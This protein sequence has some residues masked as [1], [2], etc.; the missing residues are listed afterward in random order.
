MERRKYLLDEKE[1]FQVNSMIRN[2]YD[3]Q[4]FFVVNILPI[5]V[6]KIPFLFFRPK[7]ISFVP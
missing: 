2:V 6:E 4:L 7:E 5:E 3:A 1:S